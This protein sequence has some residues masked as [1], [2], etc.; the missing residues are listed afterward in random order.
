MDVTFIVFVLAA[1][2][3]GAVPFGLL[4]GLAKGVDIRK[5]GSGN[6]GATNAGRVL[7]RKLGIVCFALDVCKGLGPALGYGLAAGLICGAAANVGALVTLK[8][9][10]VAVAAI[11]GHVFP[12]YLKFQ[13]GK[14]V[15][16]A[17]GALLGVFPVLSVAALV[18]GVVWLTVVKRTAYVSLASIAAALS[19][20]VAAVLAALA[21]GRPMAQWLVFAGV[22]LLLAGL[23]VVKHRSN[24]R[25][26]R[27]GEEAK[28]DWAKRK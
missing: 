22:T 7:G 18:A 8:W 5:A 21:L 11:L 24:I 10:A 3:I 20:P 28:V 26:L 4:L 13:G 6:I 16:T 14:G 19:L 15:A 27:A 23:V 9:L 2:L 17:L 25:R 1:Y 12:I